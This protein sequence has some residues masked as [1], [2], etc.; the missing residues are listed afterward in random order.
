MHLFNEYG[1]IKKYDSY[2]E[3][4]RNF[5]KVRLD[6][7]QKRKDHLLG[8]WRKEMDILK[9]KVKFIMYV[10]EGKIIIFKNG[11]SKKKDEIMQKLEELEF[12]K[13]ITGIEKNASYNYIT[14]T[15][16][17]NLTH[18]EVERLK[19]QLADKKEEVA[20][21]ESKTP[22]DIWIEELEEFMEAYDKWE[23]E[24]DAHYDG[25]LYKNVKT[26]KKK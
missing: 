8:K 14:S 21:L 17:F 18:E 10:I 22:K 3:I 20:I 15:G 26:A 2:G 11:K 12:P 1:K 25:L 6:L 7:Y 19:Q 5:S 4:L 16:L 23:S 24:T 13:F 9:W